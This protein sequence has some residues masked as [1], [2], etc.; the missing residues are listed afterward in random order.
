MSAPTTGRPRRASR[1]VSSSRVVKP[2]GSAVP[3]AVEKMAVSVKSRF[4]LTDIVGLVCA[5]W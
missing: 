3:V 2:P 5:G 1:M 4:E